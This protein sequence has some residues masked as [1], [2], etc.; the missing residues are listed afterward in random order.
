VYT[1]RICSKA[2]ILK[3]TSS[4]ATMLGLHT[5]PS[6]FIL[7]LYFR[8]FGGVLNWVMCYVVPGMPSD[9]NQQR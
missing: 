5:F 3:Y 8:F 7:T 4:I 6:N 2:L 1:M 9:D